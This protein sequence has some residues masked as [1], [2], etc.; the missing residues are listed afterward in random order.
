MFILILFNITSQRRKIC[1]APN[2]R[3]TVNARLEIIKSKFA[4]IYFSHKIK[5]ELS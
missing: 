2:D 1:I 5:A 4:I 3:L